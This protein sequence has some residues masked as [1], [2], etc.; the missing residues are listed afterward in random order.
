M[1]RRQLDGDGRRDG[2]S[3]AMDSTAMDGE[4]M[5]DSDSTGMDEEE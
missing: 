4:G 2:H 5:L 3:T 1:M